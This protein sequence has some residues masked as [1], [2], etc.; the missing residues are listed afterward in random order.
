MLPLN[1][2]CAILGEGFTTVYGDVPPET[3]ML[4]VC[5]VKSVK[6]VWLKDIFPPEAT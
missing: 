3:T 5:P 1:V 6:E 2:V 4:N